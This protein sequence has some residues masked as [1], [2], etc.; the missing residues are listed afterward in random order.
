MKNRPKRNDAAL[1]RVSRSLDGP[2]FSGI[3]SAEQ[4]RIAK[5]E[6]G[7]L[8]VGIAVGESAEG[9][10]LGGRGSLSGAASWTRPRDRGVASLRGHMAVVWA[11]CIAEGRELPADDSGDQVKLHDLAVEIVGKIGTQKRIEA[12][13]RR[14]KFRAIK[15]VRRHR[16]EIEQLAHK[17]C[18]LYSI[19]DGVK[20]A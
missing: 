9:I 7:H 6:S 10:S 20:R 13:I 12:E 19:I 16:A 2:D 15:L 5:H 11:G 18:E 1:E 3:L 4:Q 14:A 8:V 17:L